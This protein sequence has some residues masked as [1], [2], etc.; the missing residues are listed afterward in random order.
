MQQLKI[1]H[2]HAAEK[3]SQARDVIVT[4]TLQYTCI[5]LSTATM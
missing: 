2:M 5:H 1:K 4:I 3:P